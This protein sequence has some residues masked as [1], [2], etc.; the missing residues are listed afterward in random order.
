MRQ[1]FFPVSRGGPGF[2][3]EPPVYPEILSFSGERRTKL[4]KISGYTGGS[5]KKTWTTSAHRKKSLFHHPLTI[6]YPQGKELTSKK[7][8]SL[9]RKKNVAK[10]DASERANYNVTKK[11]RSYTLGD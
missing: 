6:K 10:K 1:G 3:C 7:F 9:A 2:F 11:W 8:P 4:V 5:Q